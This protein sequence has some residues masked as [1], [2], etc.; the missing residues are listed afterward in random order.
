MFGERFEKWLE[1]GEYCIVHN[2]K[3]RG[4]RG[5]FRYLIANRFNKRFF[6]Y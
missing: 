3:R 6:T 5:R 2:K 1:G 4:G